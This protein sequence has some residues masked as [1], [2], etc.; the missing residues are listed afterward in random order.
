MHTTTFRSEEEVGEEGVRKRLVKEGFGE[1]KIMRVLKALATVQTDQQQKPKAG[2]KAKNYLCLIKNA[3]VCE[4]KYLEHFQSFQ[5]SLQKQ[6]QR[7]N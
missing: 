2:Q 4:R 7:N 3:T 5:G 1:T 6:S